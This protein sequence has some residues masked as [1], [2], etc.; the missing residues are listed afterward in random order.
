ME[1]PLKTPRR[2]L[3][4]AL[5]AA[6]ALY[7]APRALQAAHPLQIPPPPVPLRCSLGDHTDI[8]PLGWNWN[9]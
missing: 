1:H 3:A 4:A 9:P 7:P 2:P 5:L 8:S 6:C